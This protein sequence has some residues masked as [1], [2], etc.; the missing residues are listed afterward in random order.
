MYLLRFFP[1]F[2]P[3]FYYKSPGLAVLMMTEYTAPV[4]WL[5]DWL[6]LIW[7]TGINRILEYKS[8]NLPLSCGWVCSVYWPCI[9]YYLLFFYTTGTF[10]QPLDWNWIPFWGLNGWNRIDLYV[11]LNGKGTFLQPLNWNWIPISGLNGWSRNWFVRRFKRE[12]RMSNSLRMPT[13]R[14]WIG[15]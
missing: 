5:Y 10:L 7:N 11:D 1:A 8:R 9:T 2:Y 6:V 3:Y 15:A 14:S 4:W 12:R 13:G